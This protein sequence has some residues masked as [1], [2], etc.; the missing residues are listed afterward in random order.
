MKIKIHLSEFRRYKEKAI[1]K[2]K[3]DGLNR[4]QEY[5]VCSGLNLP[6]VYTLILE[7]LEDA[8]LEAKRDNL[9][10]FYDYR[11]VEWFLI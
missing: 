1:A 3:K 6:A 10:E 9:V 11:L 8:A 2:Y 5:C 4:L 7:E